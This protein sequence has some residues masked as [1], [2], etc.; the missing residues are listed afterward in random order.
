M[1]IAGAPITTLV[2]IRDKVASS[3]NSDSSM[4]HRARRL[5]LPRQQDQSVSEGVRG[6]EPDESRRRDDSDSFNQGRFRNSEIPKGQTRT[7][8]AGPNADAF[9]SLQWSESSTTSIVNRQSS[10]F[11]SSSPASR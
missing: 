4:P 7:L 8:I 9:S 2:A 5:G 1:A 3:A 10:S 11:M 6:L